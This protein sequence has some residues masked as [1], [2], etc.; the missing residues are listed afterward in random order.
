M[1]NTEQNVAIKY[2]R[3]LAALIYANES[4]KNDKGVKLNPE[5]VARD[6]IYKASVLWKTLPEDWKV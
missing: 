4:F 1:E 3:D 5:D 2:Q 6:A